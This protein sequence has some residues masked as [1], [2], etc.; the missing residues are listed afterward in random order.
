[1]QDGWSVLCLALKLGVTLGNV[2]I[3]RLLLV[4]GTTVDLAMGEGQETVL[5][6]A[7]MNNLLDGARLLFEFRANPNVASKRGATALH[8]AAMQ[9]R[10]AAAVGGAGREERGRRRR[11]RGVNHHIAAERKLSNVLGTYSSS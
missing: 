9:R 2:V 10:A 8:C 11:G 3:A 5:M 6:A 1:M 7:A 4:A